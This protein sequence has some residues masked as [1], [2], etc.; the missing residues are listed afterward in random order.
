M[1]VLVAERCVDERQALALRDAFYKTIGLDRMRI[2]KNIVRLLPKP[3]DRVL[4]VGTGKGALTRVLAREAAQVVS[5]DLSAD[6]Q[7]FAAEAL[8]QDRSRA[9]VSLQVADAIALPFPDAL[10]GT[11]VCAFSFHHFSKP[12]EAIDEMLRVCAGDLA[13]VEFNRNGFDAVSRAHALT[14]EVHKE[15]SISFDKAGL[16]L[17]ER[18]LVVQAFSDEWFDMFL[19]SNKRR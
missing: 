6:E 11:V 7:A 18:G 2:R 12:F 9:K 5:I 15:G 16:Y 13:L 3:L 8:S 14:G 17:K 10:F 4:E 1:P 19:L